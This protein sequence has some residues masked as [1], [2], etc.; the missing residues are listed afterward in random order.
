MNQSER[1][2]EI[3]RLHRESTRIQLKAS[4]SAA[5]YKRQSERINTVLEMLKVWSAFN[6]AAMWAYRDPIEKE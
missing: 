4:E 2:I 1:I 3:E 6:I 5:R